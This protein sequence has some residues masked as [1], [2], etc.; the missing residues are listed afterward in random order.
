MEI[1]FYI[2]EDAVNN[3]EAADYEAF[4]RAQDG[5]IKV[6]RLRPA[7]CRF[8]VDEKNNPIPYEQAL[9]VSEKMKISQL[10]E[11][12]TK[13]FEAASQRAVPN[14]NGNK[15]ESPSEVPSAD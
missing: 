14:E 6:Y 15:S 8:M 4:E 13:F 11:F 1:N 2:T 5:D 7:L 10:K 3:M 9:K 12:V